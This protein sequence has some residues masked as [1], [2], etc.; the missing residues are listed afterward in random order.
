MSSMQAALLEEIRALR[1]ELRSVRETQTEILR[2]LQ[3]KRGAAT[4]ESHAALL[5]AIA[6]TWGDVEPFTA[7]EL[8]RFRKLKPT[9]RDA[10]AAVYVDSPKQLGKLFAK[11]NGAPIGGLEVV[12]VKNDH[13]G[14]IL[15]RV[16][17][18]R[19]CGTPN[20]AGAD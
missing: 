10:I 11:L 20:P 18:S 5:L 6:D 8:L 4:A 14:R 2:L 3:R 7:A 9:L 16:R 17:V 19:V 12:Q 13:R 1:A 15:W